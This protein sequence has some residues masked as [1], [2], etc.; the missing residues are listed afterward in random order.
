MHYILQ[1]QSLGSVTE[2]CVWRK[3]WNWW[4]KFKSGDA[5]SG[6][7]T[8]ATMGEKTEDNGRQDSYQTCSGI[9]HE[10]SELNYCLTQFLSGRGNFSS[11]IHRMGKAKSPAYRTIILMTTSHS[12]VLQAHQLD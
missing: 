5:L 11:Y 6:T 7:D 3:S 12:H 1:S 9:D 8:T 2:A 4:T 10:D